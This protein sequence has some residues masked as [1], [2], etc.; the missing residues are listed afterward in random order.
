MECNPWSWTKLYKVSITGELSF[1]HKLLTMSGIRIGSSH[2]WAPLWERVLK[3]CG[4]FWN[5]WLI[6]RVC[7]IKLVQ[8]FCFVC[9]SSPHTPPKKTIL[10]LKTQ[11]FLSV[12]II[13]PEHKLFCK[14]M[15]I[16]ISILTNNLRKKHR[17]NYNL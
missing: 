6:K 4:L 1:R 3:L 11:K 9:N 16:F 2:P 14:N 10:K 8:S 12:V 15:I 7:P 17:Q 13:K 5:L